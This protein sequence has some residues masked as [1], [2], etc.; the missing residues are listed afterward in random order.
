MLANHKSGTAA[1]VAA[2]MLRA[3]RVPHREKNTSG[4]PPFQRIGDFP[5]PRP[6]WLPSQCTEDTATEQARTP[7]H[8][9][10]QQFPLQGLLA[11]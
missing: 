1:V 8:A 7:A 6:S 5:L 4:S 9:S 10:M 11:R 2:L 3:S